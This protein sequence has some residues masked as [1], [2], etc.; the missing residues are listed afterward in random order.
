HNSH[1]KIIR[2]MKKLPNKLTKKGNIG[3][4]GISNSK[5]PKLPGSNNSAPSLKIKRAP[6]RSTT[7]KEIPRN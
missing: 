3:T 1:P 2:I 5:T 6:I 4:E 7:P